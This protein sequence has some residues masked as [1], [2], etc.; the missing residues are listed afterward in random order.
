MV[1]EAWGHHD[2]PADLNGDRVV[3]TNDLLAILS[4]W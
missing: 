2:S 4:A 1:I 3:N